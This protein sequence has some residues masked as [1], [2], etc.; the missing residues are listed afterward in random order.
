MFFIGVGN[1]S[2]HI[3]FTFI[4]SFTPE[5]GVAWILGAVIQFIGIMCGPMWLLV[6]FYFST[7]G[8]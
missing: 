5:A 3:I 4:E 6:L 2:G 1:V 7:T 8:F